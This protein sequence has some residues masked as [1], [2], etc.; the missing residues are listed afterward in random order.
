[1][2][3]I[4]YTMPDGGIAVVTPVRN[5]HPVPETLTDEEIE[6]RA[7]D[8]IPAD[9]L[10]PRWIEADQVPAERAYRAAWKADGD[11]IAHDMEKAREIHK[12]KLRKLRAPKLAE[13]DTAYMRADEAADVAEKARIETAKQ[14]LR[15]ITADPRIAAAQSVDDLKR[16]T[17]P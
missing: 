8:K 14:Q 11:G 15:D 17:L 9:A 6:Q 4:V 13:L 10:N 5:T 2:R 16:V 12:A 1:M 3:K 7:W